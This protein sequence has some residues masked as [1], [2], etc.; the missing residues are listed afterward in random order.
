MGAVIIRSVNMLDLPNEPFCRHGIG[1][2]DDDDQAYVRREALTV[3]SHVFQ[4]PV[5]HHS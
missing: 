2:S 5:V 1:A 4:L 3:T